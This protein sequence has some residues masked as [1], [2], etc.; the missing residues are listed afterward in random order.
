V[1]LEVKPSLKVLKDF[2]HI[3]HIELV[4]YLGQINIT[5]D[6]NLHEG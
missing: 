6:I 3:F 2:L 5:V 1:V 4:E